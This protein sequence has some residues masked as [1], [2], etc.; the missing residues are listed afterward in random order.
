MGA[1]DVPRGA[2]P[3]DAARARGGNRPRELALVVGAVMKSRRAA[4]AE[5]SVE[6]V[7]RLP[8]AVVHQRRLLRLVEDERPDDQVVHLGAHEAAPGVRRRA[9]GGAA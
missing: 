7:L 4:G 9:G 2:T 6:L 8:R 3:E 5:D 1:R